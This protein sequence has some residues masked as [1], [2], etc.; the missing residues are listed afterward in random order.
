MH[1]KLLPYVTH[2]SL[3]AEDIAQLYNRYIF[4]WT[5]VRSTRVPKC[6][7]REIAAGALSHLWIC[8]LLKIPGHY[9]SFLVFVS[10][11]LPISIK[12]LTFCGSL[13]FTLLNPL[14]SRSWPKTSMP[15]IYRSQF[16]LE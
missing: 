15:S 5:R 6:I 7:N 16:H 14:Y 10:L 3:E 9:H 2:S 4:V 13:G 8:S 1:N 11:A 12:F